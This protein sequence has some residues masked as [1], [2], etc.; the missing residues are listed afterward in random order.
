MLHWSRQSADRPVPDPQSCVTESWPAEHW[1]AAVGLTS[2]SAVP[3]TSPQR[4][5]A[6]LCCSLIQTQYLL[7]NIWKSRPVTSSL[8]CFLCRLQLKPSSAII[9]YA[10]CL[11]KWLVEFVKSLLGYEWA[12]CFKFCFFT[13]WVVLRVLSYKSDLSKSMSYTLSSTDSTLSALWK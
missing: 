6:G 13:S 1:P 5:L 11:L 7:R 2:L 10:A 9:I 4:L 3:C 12:F 8:S